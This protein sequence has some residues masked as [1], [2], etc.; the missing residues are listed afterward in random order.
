MA[1]SFRK[2]GYAQSI[3]DADYL[4]NL[5]EQWM[6]VAGF[7]I[8]YESILSEKREVIDALAGILGVCDIDPSKVERQIDGLSYEDP[9]PKNEF[10]HRVNLYHKGHRTHG[11]T[12]S[13]AN[14]LDPILVKEVEAK[15]Q[16]WFEQYGYPVSSSTT[17]K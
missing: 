17:S 13:W 5:H 2:F 7:V 10:Y 15:H 1:S 9:G 14:C 11:G 6:T 8:S 4:V 3:E 12:G 16:G